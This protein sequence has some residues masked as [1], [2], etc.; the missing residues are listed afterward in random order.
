[1]LLPT[2]LRRLPPVDGIN[3]DPIA[4]VFFSTFALCQGVSGRSHLHLLPTAPSLIAKSEIAVP[5]PRL[6]DD[7]TDLWSAMC[8]AQWNPPPPQIDEQI[9][10]TRFS[11]ATTGAPKHVIKLYLESHKKLN[12][13]NDDRK[14]DYIRFAEIWQISS[15]STFGAPERPLRRRSPVPAASK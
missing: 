1:M 11:L 10:S 14:P 3:I 13:Q 8:R 6:M 15:H 12:D 4:C 9:Q 5:R 7:S 2:E